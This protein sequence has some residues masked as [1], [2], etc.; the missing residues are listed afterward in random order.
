MKIPAY[1][2]HRSGCFDGVTVGLDGGA[3]A[4]R[5][6][7]FVLAVDLWVGVV[8]VCCAREGS[9]KEGAKGGKRTRS[10]FE[11]GMI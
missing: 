11:M 10:F 7:F 8:L 4:G 1:L 6:G 3:R 5:V 9:K 2:V